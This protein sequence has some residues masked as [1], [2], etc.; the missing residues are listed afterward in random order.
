MGKCKAPVEVYSRCVG[1][2]RPVQQWNPGK[3]SEFA[4]RRM[5][6]VSSAP[7]GPIRPISP[8]PSARPAGAGRMHLSDVAHSIAPA[9]VNRRFACS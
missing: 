9:M 2:Y 1:Y 8:I 5:F 4:D 3:K 6:A 7:I